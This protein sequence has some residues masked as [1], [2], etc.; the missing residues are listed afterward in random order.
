MADPREDRPD[1][2]DSDDLTPP[3]RPAPDGGPVGSIAWAIAAVLIAIVLVGGIVAYKV[4]TLPHQIVT[5]A[6]DAGSAAVDRIEGL[7]AKVFEKI[8]GGLRPVDTVRTSI[9]SQFTRIDKT[10]KLIVLTDTITVEV[11]RSNERRILWG[12]LNL[13]TTET[14]LR[15]P[16]NKVQFFVPLVAL[17]ADDFTYDAARKRIVIRVPA[18]ML[19]REIVEVQS[20]PSKLEVET[21]AGWARLKAL[22]GKAMEAEAKKD[23]RDV[24]LESADN[25]EM[26]KKAR[27]SAE[28][29]LRSFFSDL[30]GAVQEGVRIEFEFVPAAPA[31]TPS[32]PTKTGG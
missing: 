21:K 31:P 16:D 15:A 6:K 30:A 5:D 20:D 18:P 13:G 28:E 4:S 17:N 8:G 25:L 9:S 23:L 26:H 7:A 10:P 27:A 11:T 24:V 2:D 29:H 19:D 1:A 32:T 3:P 22:S 14:R 12:K